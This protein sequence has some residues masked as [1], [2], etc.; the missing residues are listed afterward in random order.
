MALTLANLRLIVDHALGGGA[1]ATIITD[2]NGTRDHYVNSAGRHLCG[3]HRWSFLQRAPT[4]L[5]FTASTEYV[6]LP[7]DFGELDSITY[8]SAV[9]S[10]TMTSMEHIL[11]MRST[12]ATLYN[13]YFGSVVWPT[14]ANTTSE[15]GVPR[16]ELYPTPAENVTAALRI[17][18]RAGWTEL[19][20]SAS[21]ANVPKRLE[22]LLESLVRAYAQG[23]EEDRLEELLGAVA[24]GWQFRH[25]V[26]TDS[27]DMGGMMGPTRN[28]AYRLAA[29]V[30]PWTTATIADQ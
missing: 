22:P 11:E 14:Q 15:P 2:A 4:T 10:F 7:S 27:Q 25:L 6:A 28:G 1:P 16:I 18:Y 21:Y 30:D 23:R 12:G 26:E 29:S 3:M 24:A 5:N 9:Q 13:G 17:S 19:T 20:N 8:N